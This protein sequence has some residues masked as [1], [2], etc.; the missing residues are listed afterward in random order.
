MREIRNS[1]ATW[2]VPVMQLPVEL[3]SVDAARCVSRDA[4]LHLRFIHGRISKGVFL[5]NIESAN[6]YNPHSISGSKQ[7]LSAYLIEY[8]V[9]TLISLPEIVAVLSYL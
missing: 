5:Q 2:P 6:M 8:T 3:G 7:H 1:Q 4:S 9:L